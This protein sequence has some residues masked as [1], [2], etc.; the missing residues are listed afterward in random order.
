MD[1]SQFQEF[2]KS[3]RT[4]AYGYEPYGVL[5]DSEFRT[6][7]CTFSVEDF[8]SHGCQLH[9]SDYSRALKGACKAVIDR[10]VDEDASAQ[11]EL[12][13]QQLSTSIF[14]FAFVSL[15]VSKV[16]VHE[17][18]QS[19]RA[20]T[21]VSGQPRKEQRVIKEI[22]FDEGAVASQV[23]AIRSYKYHGC[24]RLK[25]SEPCNTC[26]SAF[27]LLPYTAC[28]HKGRRCIPAGHF[29]HF[30]KFLMRQVRSKHTNNEAV[31]AGELLLSEVDEEAS[32]ATSQSADVDVEMDSVV[33]G[34]QAESV[35]PNSAVPPQQNWIQEIEIDEKKRELLAAQDQQSREQATMVLLNPERYYSP[36][37]ST[38]TVQPI[39][40]VVLPPK[41]HG[42]K[43][44]QKVPDV[45]TRSRRRK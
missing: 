40:A 8:M 18:H 14:D 12:V 13:K 17:D 41:R 28:V 5:F 29:P 26:N 27:Q 10:P 15:A 11:C 36:G 16:S 19:S 34:D 38:S 4:T 42:T 43:R 33:R 20:S 25:T 35:E 21:S 32:E 3:C 30:T 39:G 22:P 1:M 9:S 7:L 37:P 23:A 6:E 2:F 45:N 31:V 24:P 44:P